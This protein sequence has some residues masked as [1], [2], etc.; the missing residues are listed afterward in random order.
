MRARRDPAVAVPMARVLPRA[1]VQVAQEAPK[2]HR[3]WPRRCVGVSGQGAPPA[4]NAREVG[5]VRRYR[6]WGRGGFGFGWC[7]DLAA[8]GPQ[9]GRAGALRPD[10]RQGQRGSPDAQPLSVLADRAAAARTAPLASLSTM[11]FAA[12]VAP[13]RGRLA[14]AADLPGAE[15]IA[16]SFQDEASGGRKGCRERRWFRLGLSVEDGR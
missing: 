3:C 10:R 16:V 9:P 1:V 14:I 2:H 8:R 15:R 4:Y 7:P 11:C 13:E 5:G 12:A 6:A